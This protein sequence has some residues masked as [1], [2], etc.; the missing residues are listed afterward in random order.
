[1]ISGFRSFG[2]TAQ[3]VELANDLTTVVGPNASGKTAL[4]QALAKMYGVTRAQRTLHRS[5]FHLPKDV[6][7]E[8]RT[9]RD[10]FI[11]V[12]VSLPELKDGSATAES[13]APTFRHQQLEGPKK[14]PMC[15]M[16]LEARWQDDNTAEGEVTQELFWVDHLNEKVEQ[17][18]KHAV[19][20]ADRGL[21]QFYYTPASRDA[22]AQIRATTGA[23]AARLIKA[24]EWS[25]G[26]RKA[27]DDATKRLSDAFGG[28]AAIGAISKALS[29]RWKELNS[30]DTDAD[31]NLSLVSKRF[32]EVVAHIQVM[33]QHGTTKIERGLDVLSDGQQSLFYFGSSSEP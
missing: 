7:P 3:R 13:V 18:D 29:V 33:F 1:M 20:P 4:L 21:I 10:L 30:E 26:T 28:E 19:S 14:M 31:P 5:D 24:I 22:A 27:V 23:L 2:P 25:K 32:E 16:R 9:T 12:V 17:N 8:D 15:R 6:A 11:D